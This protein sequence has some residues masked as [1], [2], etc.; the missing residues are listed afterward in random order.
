MYLITIDDD[1]QTITD[2]DG[3]TLSIE[4]MV[5]NWTKIADDLLLK[6]SN[7]AQICSSWYNK[8]P[9]HL[10]ANNAFGS[11]SLWIVPNCLQAT[12]NQNSKCE[13]IEFSADLISHILG[14][15]RTSD[16][17]IASDY[18]FK[19]AEP[20]GGLDYRL[21]NDRT[22]EET[23]IEDLLKKDKYQKVRRDRLC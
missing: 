12:Y 17:V 13:D 19:N 8:N 22:E 11:H 6:D 4:E 2:Y 21:G 9:K 16:I 1:V 5:N 14:V 15:Y 3:N 20:N 23:Y 7:T 18:A 10:Y